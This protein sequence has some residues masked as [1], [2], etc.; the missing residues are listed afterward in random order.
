MPRSARVAPG[1]YCYHVLNRGNNRARVFH[2]TPDYQNL[3]DLMRKACDRISMRVIAYCLMPNHFHLVVWPYDDGDL[4]KWM[5]L[6]LTGHV[7]KYQTRHLSNGHIW[8]GRFKAFAIEDDDHLLT[9][10][11]YVERNP[12]RAGLVDC[13]TSWKWS[14][15][16]GLA[17]PKTG[18]W[19]HD[20]PVERPDDWIAVVQQSHTEAELAAVRRSIDRDLPFGSA[21]WTST[22]AERLGMGLKL[23]EPGQR[24]K[25]A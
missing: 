11:R 7:R 15:L 20:G 12:L 1:G 10:I 6:T 25:I 17:E 16:A 3:I 22:T 5:Q 23:H 21:A 4:S 9:V 18:A 24:P 13:V 19:L 14:S 2:D 8:Q